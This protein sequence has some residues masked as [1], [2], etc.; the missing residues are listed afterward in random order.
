VHLEKV[1]FTGHAI[2]Q[3]FARGIS[4]EEVH[5]ILA[6]YETVA[7]YPEDTPYPS[8]L[9]LGFVRERALHVVI[10]YNEKEKTGYVVTAYDPDMAVWEEDLKS[11]RKP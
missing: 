10:G 7:S 9:I 11:R 3:M 5:T 8:R 6:R 4:I 2:R 1:V